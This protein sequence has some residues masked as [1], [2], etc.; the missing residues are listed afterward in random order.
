MLL[1]LWGVQAVS[2]LSLSVCSVISDDL[3]KGYAKGLGYA[4]LCDRDRE[5][6]KEGRLFEM[7]IRKRLKHKTTKN[8]SEDRKHSL[9]I[10]SVFAWLFTQTQ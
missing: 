8:R 1:P 9:L 4:L 6:G 2:I 3:G 7:Q 10:P 5:E